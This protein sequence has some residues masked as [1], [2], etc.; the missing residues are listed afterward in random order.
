MKFVNYMHLFSRSQF[1]IRQDE[2][3]RHVISIQL[4]EDMKMTRDGVGDK[5]ED[6][7]SIRGCQN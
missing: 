3:D 1:S 7:D 4:F 5:T 6:P 2:H